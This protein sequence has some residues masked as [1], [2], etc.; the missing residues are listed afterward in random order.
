MRDLTP[1]QTQHATLGCH[2]KVLQQTRRNSMPAG[3]HA[4]SLP[5]T[6]YVHLEKTVVLGLGVLEQGL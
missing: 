6:D 5:E 2:R 4:N 1:S 3:S